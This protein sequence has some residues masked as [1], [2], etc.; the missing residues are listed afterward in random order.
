MI[1]GNIMIKNIFNILVCP[2]CKSKLKKINDKKI[3]CIGDCGTP[4]KL[5]DNI[6][7][8]L[9]ED[10]PKFK[11]LEAE[12]HDNEAHHYGEINMI[13]SY[14]VNYYHQKY[15]NLIDNFKNESIVL[16]VGSGDGNDANHLKKSNLT[17]IQSDISFQMVKLAKNTNESKSLMNSIY[18]VSDAEMI[19][20]K[21]NSLDAVMI[22]AALH[23]L[24]SPIQFFKEAQRVLKP[25]GMLIIGFE[26]NRWPYYIIY[27]FIRLLKRI[28][29]LDRYVKSKHSDVSIGDTE[30]LGFTFSDLRLF[31][32]ESKMELVRLDRIWFILGFTHTVLSII[33]SKLPQDKSL[34]LPVRLQKIIIFIDELILSIPIIR[35]FC[36]HW[37]LVAKKNN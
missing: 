11:K 30:T 9:P 29:R 23:H 17:F 15:L 32:S 1:A 21:E 27:P 16:E 7:I 19:P 14:H 35:N 24:P 36:W 10:L 6:P 31:L 12:Y 20:C 18:V 3:K 28:V 25:D 34:D 37:T 2:I 26:P 22:V 33:N 13:N 4:F 8:L 5:K